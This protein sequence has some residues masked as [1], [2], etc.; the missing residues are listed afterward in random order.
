M[1]TFSGVPSTMVSAS[2]SNATK[3]KATFSA[4]TEMTVRNPSHPLAVT[5]ATS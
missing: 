4:S 1:N 2:P 5:A 3:G